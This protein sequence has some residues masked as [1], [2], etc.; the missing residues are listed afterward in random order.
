M[1]T[2]IEFKMALLFWVGRKPEI[3]NDDSTDDLNLPV[4]TL[5]ILIK[6]NN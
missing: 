1:N 6:R 4:L 2:Y 3:Q 5:D